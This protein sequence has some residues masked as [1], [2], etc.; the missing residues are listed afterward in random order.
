M[1][2][3]IGT[4]YNLIEKGGTVTELGKLLRIHP[5]GSLEFKKSDNCTH[6]YTVEPNV[7][8]EIRGS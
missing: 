2:W 8:Y 6:V 4:S 1:N 5:D 3:E 7:Q